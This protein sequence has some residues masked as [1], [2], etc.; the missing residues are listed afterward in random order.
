M[1]LARRRLS[2]D[3]KAELAP[4]HSRKRQNPHPLQKAQ[5]MRHPKFV[6]AF[7]LS[8]TRV[9]IIFKNK[10]LSARDPPRASGAGI[11]RS[12]PRDSCD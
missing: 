1:L 6:L 5:R 8:V 7:D 2:V 9:G 3:P 4:P 12:A 10:V 11:S